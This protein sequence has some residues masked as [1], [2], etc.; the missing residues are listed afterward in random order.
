MKLRFKSRKQNDNFKFFCFLIVCICIGI[1]FIKN[2]EFITLKY[3][4]NNSVNNVRLI[5]SNMIVDY[6]LGLDSNLIKVPNVLGEYITDIDK[7]DLNTNPDIYLYNTHQTEGYNYNKINE[8]N[9]V[10]TVLLASY[11]LREK[12]GNNNL[13]AYVETGNISEILR[14]NNWQYKYSYEASRLLLNDY[15]SKYGDTKLFIDIHRDSANY[16]KTTIDID[17]KKYARLLFVV[18]KK[19]DNY[20]EN[21]NLANEL[22]EL[23]KKVNPSLSRGISLK[24]GSGV[25]GIYNQDLN[26]NI[27]LIEI[28]GQ[29]NTITEVDNTLDIL[30]KVLYEYLNGKET[31]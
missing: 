25:N 15:L 31:T 23:V 7:N 14:S 22:N 24:D 4:L 26:S 17:N 19:H 27:I 3:V 8:Y 6:A 10:P 21:Y 28:G 18:G 5:K 20:L 2:S 1:F 13:N 11:M 29:Y 9:I 16:D 30:A 12:L